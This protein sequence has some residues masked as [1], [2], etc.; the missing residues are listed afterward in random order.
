VISERT[1]RTHVSHVLRKLQ[2]TSCTQA[3]PAAVR[4]GLVRPRTAPPRPRPRQGNKRYSAERVRGSP[5]PRTSFVS[6]G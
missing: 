1:A 4:E 5:D 3:A 2:L 6:V